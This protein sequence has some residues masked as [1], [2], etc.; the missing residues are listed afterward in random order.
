MT[1]IY[2]AQLKTKGWTVQKI[3]PHHI[4]DKAVISA[5][6]ADDLVLLLADGF[7]CT[8]NSLVPGLFAQ[9]MPV[10]SDRH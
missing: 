5:E 4:L 2:A 7:N 10:W 6:S 1:N 3:F 9:K 8:K